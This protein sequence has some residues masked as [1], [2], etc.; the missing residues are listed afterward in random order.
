MEL[1]NRNRHLAILNPAAG[2][3][4]WHKQLGPVLERL[5]Q[6]GLEIDLR[7]TSRSGHAQDLAREAWREGYRRFISIGGDGTAYEIVNGLFPLAQGA[8][9]P[10]L[11]FLPLGTGN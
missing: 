4:R 7:E 2:G 11:S 9:P 5:R 1:Q 8:E 10:T 6:A 3:G